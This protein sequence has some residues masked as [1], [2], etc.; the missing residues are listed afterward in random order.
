MKANIQNNSY[1]QEILQA[2][3]ISPDRYDGSYEL[4][5]EVIKRYEEVPEEKWTKADLNLIYFSVIGTWKSSFEHKKEKVKQSSLSGEA[6][7]ELCQIIEQIKQKCTNYET[8]EGK[9]QIGM[10]GTGSMVVD[11]Q[12]K[13]AD[14]DIRL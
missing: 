13:M 4:I 8:S 5:R 1:Y 12:N 9:A 10:F 14:K 3:E 11:P 7:K 6:K 2:S